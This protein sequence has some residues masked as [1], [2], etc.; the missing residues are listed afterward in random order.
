MPY[1]NSPEITFFGFVWVLSSIAGLAAMLRTGREITA[2]LV[3]M[4]LL[5]SGMFG[6]G[7]SLWLYDK[8]DHCQLGAVAIF[9]GLGGMTLIELFFQKWMKM[10]N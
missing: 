7:M 2:R 1:R 9:S 6:L 10:R 8:L 5:N 3:V 4:S